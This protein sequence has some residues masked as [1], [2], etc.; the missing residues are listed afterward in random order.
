M[1]NIS[2]IQKKANSRGLKLVETLGETYLLCKKEVIFTPFENHVFKGILA[3]VETY[4]D[5]EIA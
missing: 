4:I 2:N 3:E 5:R 1:H